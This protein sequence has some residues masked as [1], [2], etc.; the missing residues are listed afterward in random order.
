MRLAAIFIHWGDWE[1]LEKAVDSIYPQVDGVIQVFSYKSNIGEDDPISVCACCEEGFRRYQFE[2]DLS[3]MARENETTKRNYGL[4]MARRDGYT[5]FIML[6]ADEFYLDIEEAK[7]EFDDPELNGLVCESITYFKSP[8]LCFDDT[9]RV[10]FIHKLTPELRFVKNYH[11]PFSVNEASNPAIDPT[12]TMNIAEGVKMSKV[13]M[14]HMSFIRSD[15]R[16]KIRNSAGLRLK[17]FEAVVLNDY[18][19]AQ[20]GYRL[21]YNGKTLRRVENLFNLPEIVDSSLLA[22]SAQMRSGG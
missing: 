11:Y 2:P 14:H 21:A 22:T 16:K 12:R 20:E 18:R 9:T 7:K 5:H 8:T 13:K 15:I 3:K 6:D 1:L 19:E 17:T 10:P 4:E